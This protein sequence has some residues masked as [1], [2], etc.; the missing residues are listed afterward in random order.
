M[1]A[2]RHERIARGLFF[3]VGTGR[4]GSTLLQAML[5][6][7]PKL[8][9][10]PETHFFSRFDPAV[11]G[12]GESIEERDVEAYIAACER[13]AHWRELG[14][15]AEA[16][17][18]AVEGGARTGRALF[19]WMIASL[20][21]EGSDRRLGEKTPHH[22]R[23]WR[24]IAGLFP[25]ARF[26][27]I[28]RDPR[29]VVASVR[30]MAWREERSALLNARRCRGT[31]DRME[32]AAGELGDARFHRV[33]Y[34]SLLDDPEG[35]LRGVCAFLGEEYDPAMLAYH[36]REAAGYTASERGWKEGTRKPLDRSRIG[37]F[38]EKLTAREVWTVERVVGEHMGRLGYERGVRGVRPLWHLRDAA[39][40][41]A[42][43]AR[44]YGRGMVKRLSP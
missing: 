23:H 26:I 24:R 5:S 9:I 2:E 6:C 20:A 1:T 44:W 35:V 29:D 38:R 21:G 14:L 30:D 16:L 37:A 18:A 31:Y 3:I 43:R 13:E 40:L 33:R 32:E 27:H 25:G 42:Y 39:E 17:R 11:L 19:L 28:H 4:C 41:L 22:E 36:E 7:H 10:P 12:F 15:D 34:E 8:A